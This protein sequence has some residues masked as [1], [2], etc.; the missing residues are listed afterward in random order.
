MARLE[1]IRKMYIGKG[2]EQPPM[3]NT[4][5]D[6]IPPGSTFLNVTT[7]Q[8]WYWSGVR[9]E[10]EEGPDVGEWVPLGAGTNPEAL[11]Y[12]ILSVLYQINDTLRLLASQASGSS[13]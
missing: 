3:V 13:I 7:G 1:S 8:M 12:E 5:T 2:D 6:R 10:G 4:R 11:Q 9:A